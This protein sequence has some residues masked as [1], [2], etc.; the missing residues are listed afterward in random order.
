MP[1]L[2]GDSV[3]AA[4]AL[5]GWELLVD[6][7]GGVIVELE[8]YR[9]DDPASHA[10]RGQTARNAAMFG[11][12]GRLYIYRSYGIHWCMNI[13]CGPVGVGSA[14]LV[15]ALEPVHG[16]ETMIARR[17]IDDV[18]RLCRGPGNVGKAL[19]ATPA[20]NGVAADLRPPSRARR[21]A[22]STRIGLSVAVERPWRFADPDSRFVSRPL[23]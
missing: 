4:G 18:A 14:V 9:P 19:A 6:G 2:E 20:L 17:G 13:V 23:R 7:V 21:V 8:A 10:F 5:I 12:A 22:S 15:R 11:P 3:V 16:I 1:P